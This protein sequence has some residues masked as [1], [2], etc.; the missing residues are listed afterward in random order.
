M[1]PILSMER[2]VSSVLVNGTFLYFCPITTQF[3]VL[4]HCYVLSMSS[5]M[6][7]F[8]YNFMD[9][10][11][12]YSRLKRI[13]MLINRQN[14]LTVLRNIFATV[15]VS[16]VAALGRPFYLKPVSVVQVERERIM[17]F[18]QVTSLTLRPGDRCDVTELR[19][20]VTVT[21][22]AGCRF[23]LRPRP[24]LSCYLV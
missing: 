4:T 3:M 1:L 6:P 23:L 13:F 19:R 11:K 20:Y 14:G 8:K 15:I 24:P 12:D 2:D 10:L 5:Y 17:L 22:P 18:H 21:P 7:S 16:H 9:R